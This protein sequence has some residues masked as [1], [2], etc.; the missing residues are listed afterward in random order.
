MFVGALAI[1][2]YFYSYPAVQVEN[3]VSDPLIKNEQFIPM[4]SY[5]EPPYTAGGIALFGGFMD[6]LAMLNARDGGI[7]GVKL[8]WEEC[9]TAYRVD[10]A[11]ACYKHLKDKGPTG[12]AMFNFVNT[13]AAYA[14]MARAANDKIPIVTIGYGRADTV[15][16]SVFPY[17][18]PLLTTY[19]NQNTAK[20]KFMGRQEGGM[21]KLKGK[22][23]ANLYY[24]SGYGKETVPILDIQSKKYG[25]IVKHFPIY[26]PGL[27]QKLIWTQVDRLRPDWIILRGWGA[28]T[29]IA[30]KEASRID[31]PADRIIGVWWSGSEADVVPA[32][33]AAKGFIAAAFHPGGDEFEVIQDIRKYVYSNNQGHVKE[34]NIGSIYYNRGVIHG[35]LN[36]EAIRSAQT[37]FGNRPLS[38]EEVRWGLENLNLTKKRIKQLGAEGFLSPMKTSCADHEG[39]GKVQFLQWDGSKWTTISDWITPDYELT[40]PMAK[41]SAKRYA[42]EHGIIPRDCS[43][44]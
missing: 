3:S 26:P 4:T 37:K 33:E 10:R 17:V 2:A 35:I 22:I 25:F 23:I 43:K 21:D 42:E 14:V 44:E 30:L 36:A 7:N 29:P 32:G 28:M 16:G 31:F 40:R 20:I 24:H 8:T 11:I 38:G 13:S 18:F 5:R 41:A 12:A 27:E 9:E 15:E 39:G 34:E 19:W 1:A 6:Y